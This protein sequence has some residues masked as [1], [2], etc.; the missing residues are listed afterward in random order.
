MPSATVV[1]EAVR[2]DEVLAPQLEPVHP[3]LFRELIDRDLDHVRRLGAARPADGVG[4]HL[5]GEDAGDVG[6]HRRDVVDAAH[7]ERAQRRDRRRQQHQVG[8]EVLQDLHVERGDLAVASWR[9]S[10]PG[11]SGRGRG[12]WRACPRCATRPT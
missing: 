8:A 12:G 1:R 5:V 3:E 6:L 4:R 11:R 7:H 9:P 2:G 10:S